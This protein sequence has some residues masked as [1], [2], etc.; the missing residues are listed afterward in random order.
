MAQIFKTTTGNA[1]LDYLYDTLFGA[2]PILESRTGAPAGPDNAASGTLILSITAPVTAFNASA[3][4]S[5]TKAGT[6][7]NTAV[8]AGLAAHYRF[9][10]TGDTVRE[11]GTIGQG[12]G[13]LSLDNATFTV[14]QTGTVNTFTRSLP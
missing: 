10:N 12:T 5:K 1:L 8:A 13:D 2:S 14:G 7:S 9:K 3:A 4:K 11:E 6:W